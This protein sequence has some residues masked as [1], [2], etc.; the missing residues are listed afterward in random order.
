MQFFDINGFLQSRGAVLSRHAFA[1]W[2]K[3]EEK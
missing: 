3:W 1:D 2:L